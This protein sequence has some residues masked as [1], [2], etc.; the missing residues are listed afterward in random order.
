MTNWQGAWDMFAGHEGG[1]REDQLVGGKHFHALKGV[2]TQLLPITMDTGPVLR[3]TDGGNND[4]CRWPARP[5]PLAEATRRTRQ[6]ARRSY[7]AVTPTVLA[8]GSLVGDRF[9]GVTEHA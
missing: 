9:L 5:V 6:D 3:P 1:T 4:M 2:S 8:R 7:F